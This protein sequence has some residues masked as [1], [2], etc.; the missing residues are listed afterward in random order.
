M[1][2]DGSLT[3]RADI[4]YALLRDFRYSPV[5][6][7]SGRALDTDLVADVRDRDVGVVDVAVDVGLGHAAKGLPLQVLRLLGLQ[8]GR[9]RAADVPRTF[10]GRAG[11][12]LIGLATASRARLLLGARRHVL[13]LDVPVLEDGSLTARADIAYALLRDFRYSPVV[14]PSGRH[15]HGD[16]IADVRNGDVVVVDIAVNRRLGDASQ[17][18]LLRLL[19]TSL[20]DLRRLSPGDIPRT[21]LGRAR[22]DLVGLAATGEIGLIFW[23]HRLVACLGVLMLK[24]GTLAR[25]ADIAYALLRDHDVSDVVE[26]VGAKLVPNL[27]AEIEVRLGKRIRCHGRLGRDD[28][29]KPLPRL[30]RLLDIQFRLGLL[31]RD[32][33]RAVRILRDRYLYKCAIVSLARGG[34]LENGRSICERVPV[35]LS[36]IDVIEHLNAHPGVLVALGHYPAGE[37]RLR[38]LLYDR[39]VKGPVLVAPHLPDRVGDTLATIVRELLDLRGVP[40]PRRLLGLGTGVCAHCVQLVSVRVFDQVLNQGV[41]PLCV[42]SHLLLVVTP[43]LC[44]RG[45]IL[46][47]QLHAVVDDAFIWGLRDEIPDCVVDLGPR[48]ALQEPTDSDRD[49]PTCLG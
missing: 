10:L 16:A 21:F 24:H 7:P 45:T 23:P 43:P 27:L 29:A 31:N 25:G 5:V 37:L 47:V 48:D 1:L 14:L 20:R 18:L 19:R 13:V 39:I 11:L 35:E 2:E 3:A 42:S 41:G 22:L 33:E 32:P 8:L 26:A 46:P 6:L 28:S 4:A 40:D 9:F 15:L 12:H 38:N 17:S 34:Y 30:G 36:A 44:E 49:L